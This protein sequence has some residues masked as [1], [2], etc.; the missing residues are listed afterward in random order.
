MAETPRS[1]SSSSSNSGFFIP[2]Y[3]ES[4]NTDVDIEV[5]SPISVER[6]H[7]VEKLTHFPKL[8]AEL[9]LMVWDFAFVAT[10]SCR[11]HQ[12][13][14][15]EQTGFDR[16]GVLPVHE[17]ASPDPIRQQGSAGKSKKAGASSG[18]RCIPNGDPVS[19][20]WAWKILKNLDTLKIFGT[21]EVIFVV[22]DETGCRVKE[23]NIGHTTPVK[24]AEVVLE[25]DI[26]RKIKDE[27][28]MKAEEKVTW[29]DMEKYDLL[30][31]DYAKELYEA[32]P[33]WLVTKII[34]REVTARA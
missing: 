26:L 12:Q 20:V 25:M 17:A 21:K 7:P 23:V 19:L 16:L 15:R 1:S 8:P 13:F 30:R 29:E 31:V 18:S 32:D 2:S 14:G 34:Y 28:K 4:P 24:D 33:K 11:S 3:V 10:R 6:I 27:L 22:G 9:R 5:I